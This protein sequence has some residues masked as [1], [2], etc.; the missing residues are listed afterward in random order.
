MPHPCIRFASLLRPG[1]VPAVAGGGHDPELSSVLADYIGLYTREGLPR[2][3]ELFLPAFVA[4]AAN[5]DGSLTTW[6]LD[7]FYQRQASAFASGR[8]IRETLENTHVER[9]GPLAAVRS[10]FVWTDGEVVRRGRLM[11]Q[12][13]RE[14]GR[15]RIQ[16]LTFGYG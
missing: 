6:D 11:L 9:T 10:D 7:A 4:T 3:R 13:I 12:L 16:A 1:V 2:W 15:F 5:E 14:R 8:P